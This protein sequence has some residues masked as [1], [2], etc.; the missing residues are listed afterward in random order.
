MLGSINHFTKAC[1]L[2]DKLEMYRKLIKPFLL[3]R[4]KSTV[5]KELPEKT[6][7]VQKCYMNEPQQEFYRETRNNY[8][9]KFLEE[10]DKNNNVS[11]IL[12][13]EGLLRLR[14]AANH[15]VLVDK[16][17]A[18][19]SGK[20]E[21]VTQMLDEVIQSG[22]KVLVF[23]SFVEHL[24]LYKTYLDE[25]EIQYCYLDGSTKDRKEQ[26]EKFQHNDSFPVFLLSLKAGGVG[27]NL[28]RASYVFLL[29]PWWNPASEAQA[30]DRA[31]R[32]GQKNKVFV[33]KFIT[34]NTIEEKILKLQVEKKQLF[35]TMIESENG[36]YKKLEV[37]EIIKLIE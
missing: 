32:I 30:F 16:A 9:D 36:N 8:R 24:K 18:Q 17:F 13:L 7:I 35:D 10:R 22:D 21:T 20:F 26:V 27:L 15:P 25:K 11:P 34:Q 28:T 6:I 23:S 2:P 37:N 12:L 19:T 33:Y 14:Q 1:K 29:D 4:N 31:H 3:R 5:L